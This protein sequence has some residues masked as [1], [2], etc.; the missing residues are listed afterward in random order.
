MAQAEK[1]TVPEE[2]IDKGI[3][4]L[5]E[6]FQSAKNEHTPIIVERIVTDIDE[7]VKFV[8]FDGWQNTNQGKQEVK[9]ALRKVIWGKYK[10]KD[11]EVFGKAYHYVETYY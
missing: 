8:R 2:G 7:I 11:S 4:A 3:A 1:E 5:T 10:I 9:Q 6:L